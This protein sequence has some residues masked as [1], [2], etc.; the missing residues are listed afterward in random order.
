MTSLVL[1][2]FFVT[3]LHYRQ[4]DDGGGQVWNIVRIHG[5]LSAMDAVVRWEGDANG[6]NMED[7][8][9][10]VFNTFCPNN[11]TG[12]AAVRAK[13]QELRAEHAAVDRII[14]SG[15]GLDSVTNRIV[16]PAFLWRIWARVRAIFL[17]NLLFYFIYVCGR[18]MFYLF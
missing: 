6:L 3:P 10:N 12:S 17:F 13:I 1:L 14:H 7:V 9:E 11:S 8:I 15:F 4:M 2:A 5:L 16:G 18:R